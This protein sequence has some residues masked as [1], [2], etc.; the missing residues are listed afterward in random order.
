MP[1]PNDFRFEKG[2]LLPGLH[3]ADS[4]VAVREPGRP[5]GRT[6]EAKRLKKLEAMER[7][8]ADERARLDKERAAFEAERSGKG[9]K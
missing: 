6:T 8:M 7:E 5:D 3:P 1:G 9:A 2:Q 4:G